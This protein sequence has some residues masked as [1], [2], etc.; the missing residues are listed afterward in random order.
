[1]GSTSTLCSEVLWA[2]S[3]PK[4]WLSSK[5]L[6]YNFLK[7]Q[8]QSSTQRT[9]TL[10]EDFNPT[11]KIL[12]PKQAG[13]LMSVSLLNYI[14]Q[15]P[16]WEADIS[17]ANQESS[18]FYKTRIL[19][20]RIR[21]NRPLFLPAIRMTQ[22]TPSYPTSLGSVLILFPHL[23]LD[24]PSGLFSQISQQSPVPILSPHAYHTSRPSHSHWLNHPKST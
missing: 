22:S 5:C 8:T 4:S 18:T 12:C 17:S 9:A 6:G 3:R 2:N 20:N 13:S 15:N 21:K 24:L 19:I 23:R 11:R 7:S 1:M 14:K 16:H 10:S